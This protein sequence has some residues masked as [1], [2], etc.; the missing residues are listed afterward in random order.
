VSFPEQTRRILALGH[1]I[2]LHGDCR[3]SPVGLDPTEESFLLDRSLRRLRG[4]LGTTFTPRGYRSPAWDLSARTVG[5]LVDRGYLYDSSMMADD[6]RPYRA[7]RDDRVD[8]DCLT[9]GPQTALVEMPVAWELDDFPCF[10]H[11]NRPLY[12]PPR[13]VE[14]VF[15][16]WRDEFDYCHDHVG[17]GVFTLTLHPQII[18][19]GPRILMLA[20]LVQHMRSRPGVTFAT[21][22]QA[23]Q[24]AADQLA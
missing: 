24:R 2:G 21:L 3:E 8:E 5:L 4:V 12:G 23:A 22:G 15:A 18:G 1:E 7:R 14:D 17:G 16:S 20:R 13:N 9:R 19:R 6:F 11:L 10:A